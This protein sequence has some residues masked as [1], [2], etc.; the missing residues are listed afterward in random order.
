MVVHQLYHQVAISPEPAHPAKRLAPGPNRPIQY[1]R[2]CSSGSRVARD[3]CLLT[4]CQVPLVKVGHLPR[5]KQT[6]TNQRPMS[7]CVSLYDQSTQHPKKTVHSEKWNEGLNKSNKHNGVTSNIY[8]YIISINMYINIIINYIKFL[9]STVS[10]SFWRDLKGGWF[11]GDKDSTPL[12]AKKKGVGWD[13][14]GIDEAKVKHASPIEWNKACG[15]FWTWPGLK[16]V[17]PGKVT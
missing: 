17:C 15:W 8:I 10:P 4:S 2:P 9:K 6:P 16:I 14:W 12:P 5:I 13:F 1:H 11:T 3:D 7:V